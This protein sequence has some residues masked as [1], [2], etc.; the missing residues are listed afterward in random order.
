MVSISRSAFLYAG[1]GVMLLTLTRKELRGPVLGVVVSGAAAVLLLFPSL[2][3]LL[4]R[5]AAGV[6]F[7]D[8]LW[9][10]GWKI[11][12]E[13]PWTGLGMGP[14]IFESTRAIYL[15]TF[16]HRG[17]SGERLRPGSQRLSHQ[18]SGA[19]LARPR[20]HGCPVRPGRDP[21]PLRLPGVPEGGLGPGSGC[22]RVPRPDLAGHVRERRHPGNGPRLGLADLL[23]LRGSSRLAG[24]LSLAEPLPFE[25]LGVDLLDPG[26]H[27][28]D[29]EPPPHP[30]AG[31]GP[32]LPRALGV[33]QECLHRLGQGRRILERHQASRFPFRPRRPPHRPRG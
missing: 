17:S 30:P 28:I 7:R 24:G 22:R 20:D 16:A 31:G 12:N 25:K 5:P 3:F 13:N 1:L 32:H 27:C 10:T 18:G 29:P 9:M 33:N 19:G 8:S 21:R 26:D 2:L 15:P 4:L 23:P 14:G 11:L 6:S